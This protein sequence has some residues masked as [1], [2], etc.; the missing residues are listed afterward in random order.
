MSRT[1][2]LKMA[3]TWAGGYI[4]SSQDNAESG[5]GL[6]A[7]LVASWQASIRLASYMLVHDVD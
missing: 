1:I 2:L 7:Q 5:Y 4:D 6:W 3:P